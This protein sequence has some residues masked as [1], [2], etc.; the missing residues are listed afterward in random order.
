MKLS[1]IEAAI[2][3]EQAADSIWCS[4]F[5]GR[6]ELTRAVFGTGVER[7]EFDLEYEHNREAIER[8]DEEWKCRLRQLPPLE[9]FA[10]EMRHGLWTGRMN[11]HD[12][13][14]LSKM[15]KLPTPFV[16]ALY[17]AGLW[18]LKLITEGTL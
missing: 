4:D 14:S 16:Q 9:R 15:V 2:A 10:V 13:K 5:V 6:F 3:K 12:F 18:R 8:D 11:P 7:H 1:E 17:N